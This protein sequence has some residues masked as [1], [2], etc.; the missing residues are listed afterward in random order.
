MNGVHGLV[1]AP[2]AS[3]AVTVELRIALGQ[4]SLGLQPVSVPSGTLRRQPQLRS[5]SQHLNHDFVEASDPS[6]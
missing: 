6:K 4:V 5:V 3:H 2:A 1:G